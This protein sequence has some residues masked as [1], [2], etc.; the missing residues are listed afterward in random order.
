[1]SLSHLVSAQPAAKKL[2]QLRQ[3]QMERQARIR[4][5]VED[6]FQRFDENGDGMLQRAELRA[7]LAWLHPSRPPT[8]EALDFLITKA[9]AVV[10]SSL[11]LPGRKDGSVAW[12]DARETVLTYGDMVK[13]QA[14]I[15]NVFFLPL[16]SR[17]QRDSRADGAARALKAVAP[18]AARWTTPTWRTCWSSA[19]RMV[20][21]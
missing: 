1:M 13:D 6:W 19:T 8:E 15:D 20:T 21:A 5:E 16:R 9:T 7:L 18:E 4:A 2:K 11:S 3:R 10:T 17:P 14:Y 12:H